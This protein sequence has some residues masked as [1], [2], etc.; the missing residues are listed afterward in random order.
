MPVL[1]PVVL[2]QWPVA[3]RVDRDAFTT[4]ANWRSYSSVTGGGL[5]LG[6]K[7]HSWRDLLAIPRAASRS[8][9]PALAIHPAEEKDLLALDQHGWQLLD[10][11]EVAGTPDAY[12]CFVQGSLAELGIAKAG[13]VSS[14]SGWFSDRSACYL[15][16]GRPVIAQDTGF[17]DR[18]PTGCGL[19]PFVTTEAAGAA[20][21]AV[22]AH[23]ER[24]RRAARALA[25]AHLDAR[26]VLTT[27]LEHLGAAR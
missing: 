10:P 22:V 14:R 18:L 5:V 23:Y 4:V 9:M 16:S 15:A 13:Y 6:Q 20:T 25:E 27:V 12:R 17:G 11:A 8:C 1:P 26:A 19:L 3:E 2:D 7:A 24:H 21:D